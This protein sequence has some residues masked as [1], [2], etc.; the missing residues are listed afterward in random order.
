[1]AGGP[2]GPGV[3]GGAAVRVTLR[4]FTLTE[5]A[6]EL[7][8]SEMLVRR[9]VAEGVLPARRIGRR[10]YV[11]EIELQEW[12]GG[13]GQPPDRGPRHRPSPM[14]PTDRTDAT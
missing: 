4:L 8:R 2:A 14:A 1:M 10:W 12:L 13:S 9:L 6:C 3:P 11:S 5:A 7:G